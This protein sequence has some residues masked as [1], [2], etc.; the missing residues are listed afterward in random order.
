MD[1]V[2]VRIRKWERIEKKVTIWMLV[3]LALCASGIFILYQ[4][5]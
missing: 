5:L 3:M 4:I 2:I 1:P